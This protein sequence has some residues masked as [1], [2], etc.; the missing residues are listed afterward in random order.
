MQREVPV[1]VL[2]DSPLHLQTSPQNEFLKDSLRGNFWQFL[3]VYP[4]KHLH[5]VKKKNELIKIDG[6][7]LSVYTIIVFLI[8]L[9][10]IL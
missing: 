3:I 1:P 10:F 8:L 4:I 7:R 9:R 2:S 5:A 6:Q